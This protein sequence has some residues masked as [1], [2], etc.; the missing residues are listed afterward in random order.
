MAT[1]DYQDVLYEVRNHVA[2]IIINRP[3][4]M[5]AFRART[6]DELIDAFNRAGYDRE[7]GAIVFAGAGDRAFCTGGDQSAHDGQY[8]GRGTIGMQIEALHNIIRD[9]PKP[10]IARVQGYAI[11]GGNVLATISDMTICSDKAIFGQVGPKMGSVDPGYGTA[12]LA[13]VVGEKKAREIWYM[14]RRYSGPEAVEMGLANLCVPADELDATVQSWAEELCQRSP[15]AL[16]IA[17]RSFNMDTAHQA[18]IA[19]MGLYALKLYYDTEE[20]RE[21]VN[22]LNEKRTPDFRKYVK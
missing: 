21:G 5:N 18:G 15:T 10:V 12:F 2:W 11:G 19:G 22:A 16:A 20:S 9:V 3:E 13:R 6:C 7:I 1:T 17:K 14:C 4:V 8:D